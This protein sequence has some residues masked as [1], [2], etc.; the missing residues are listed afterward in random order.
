M[1]NTL[2]VFALFVMLSLLGTA[3]L[4]VSG[5]LNLKC[6]D[7]TVDLTKDST[8]KVEVSSTGTPAYTTGIVDVEFDEKVFELTNIVFNDDLAPNN[9]THLLEDEAVD[10]SNLTE[11]FAGSSEGTPVLSADGIFTVSFGDDLK[12]ENYT[13][14]GVLFTLTFKVSGEATEES[15]PIT[16]KAVPDSFLDV[17]MESVTVTLENGTITKKAEP[18]TFATTGSV[19]SSGVE[20]NP[21][22]IRL[23]P[24]GSETA[25]KE[26]KV[27]G[28]SVE[29]SISGISPGTYTVEVSKSKHV[30]RTYEIDITNG[31]VTLD[32]KILL[33][34]DVTQ[35]GIINASDATQV[36]RYF[37]GKTSM[38]DQADADFKVYLEKVADVTRDT[39]VNAS[40]ATQI[41]RFFTG[42]T[43][44]FDTIP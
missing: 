21:V 35:D 33:Y 20:T 18:A 43:S 24:K 41:K 13:K 11:Y 26:I 34:G 37:T 7:V 36:K 31:D 17:D 40:D 4:A 12:D 42:K 44:M 25:E 1:K 29:Y 10:I 32:L 23:I 28:N 16:L 15:Y 38:F 3:V 6:E 27:T 9:A 30:T 19:Q 2:T 14:A 5:S 22:T 8:F 39:I